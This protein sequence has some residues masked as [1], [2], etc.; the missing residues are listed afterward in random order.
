MTRACLRWAVL[1]A[2]LGSALMLAANTQAQIC[3]DYY[4]FGPIYSNVSPFVDGCME[5]YGEEQT[6]TAEPGGERHARAPRPERPDGRRHL[7]RT[8]ADTADASY[9]ECPYH[10]YYSCYEEGCGYDDFSDECASHD[11]GAD[12]TADSLHDAGGP[13]KSRSR[14]G[15]VPPERR[16]RR[17]RRLPL[18]HSTTASTHQDESAAEHVDAETTDDIWD[19]A[20]YGDDYD[21]GCLYDDP[22][23]PENNTHPE[24]DAGQTAADPV[25]SLLDDDPCQLRTAL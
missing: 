17:R 3:T 20:D 7:A 14:R 19:E 18:T 9:C 16:L 10:G 24:K 5:A 21:D 1:M 4:R 6:T 13:A 15:R 22:C 12:A 11:R 2:T 25:E 8:V 23:D